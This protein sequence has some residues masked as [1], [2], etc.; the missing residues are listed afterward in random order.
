MIKKVHVI[1]LNSMKKRKEW[2]LKFFIF[3]QGSKKR[4]FH[5]ILDQKLGSFFLVDLKFLIFS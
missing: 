3:F 2:C 5:Y 1:K 4:N